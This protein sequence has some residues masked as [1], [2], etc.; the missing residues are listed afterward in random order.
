MAPIAPKGYLPRLVDR[1]V[2]RSLRVF[3]AVEIAGTKWC[4]KTWT[5]L[6]HGQSVSYVDELID[7]ARDDPA[8][9][10]VGDQPHVIDEWQRVPSIWDVVRHRID[11]TRGLRGGWILTGSSTP[12]GTDGDQPVHSGAGRIG[13]VRMRPMSLA[14]SGGST[15]SVSL[16]ALFDGKF[17]PAQVKTDALQI[18]NLACRGGWP[19]ALDLAPTD[20]QEIAR[21]YLRLYGTQ[22]APHFGKDPEITRRLMFSLARN[23]GRAASRAFGKTREHQAQALSCRPFARGC[24]ACD[25]ARFSPRGLADVRPRY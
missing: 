9:M 24:G 22:T 25:A 3:G 23:L 19:E 12:F 2:E 1:K 4:G 5:A 15:R 14:E 10:L 20:A 8:M 16:A 17:E 18:V 21:E 7:L 13:R 6:Q 11:E